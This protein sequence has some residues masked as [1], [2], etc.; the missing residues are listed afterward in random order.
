MFDPRLIL[1]FCLVFIG[2]GIFNIIMGR[3]RMRQA[4]A[5]GQAVIWYKQIAILTGIEYILLSAAFLLSV[6]LSYG[7]LPP[8]LNS[9]VIP[10]YLIILLISAVLAGYV[11][12]QGIVNARKQRSSRPAQTP[13]RTSSVRVE[14]SL[15]TPEEHAEHVRKRRERRQKAAVARRRRAGKA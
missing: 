14:E 2:L 15:M 3:R 1:L 13:Q 11:I 4:R 10:S 8:A 9:L 7:W 5:Q 12:Y 6:S